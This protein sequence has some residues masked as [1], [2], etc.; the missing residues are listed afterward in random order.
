MVDKIKGILKKL[1][2]SEIDI[3][4]GLDDTSKNQQMKTRIPVTIEDL[5]KTTYLP[6]E[7]LKEIEALLIEKGQKIFY[8]PPGTGKTFIAIHFAKYLKSKYDGDYRIVQFHPSYSYEDFV[9]G[10]KPIITNGALE[11]KPQGYK[12]L[13]H[14]CSTK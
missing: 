2:V 7:T 12:E 5:T 9:E 11:Y 8:G 14:K 10:I 13:L 4:E 3:D 6:I 1:G